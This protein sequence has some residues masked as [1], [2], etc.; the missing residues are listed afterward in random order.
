MFHD[1]TLKIGKWHKAMFA[2]KHAYLY[3]MLAA[4]DT[5]IRVSAFAFPLGSINDMMLSSAGWGNH[6]IH[7]VWHDS[8]VPLI[9]TDKPVIVILQ[10]AD[11][12]NS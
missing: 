8:C 11:K 5:A 6:Y 10:N 2:V 4:Y 1:P 12:Q 9:E 7:L 3:Y